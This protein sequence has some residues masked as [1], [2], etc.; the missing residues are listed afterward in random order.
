VL[1]N[2]GLAKIV[3]ASMRAEE[4]CSPDFRRKRPMVERLAIQIEAIFAIEPTD[5]GPRFTR[6]FFNTIGA[7]RPLSRTQV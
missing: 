3:T 7:K 5:L 4:K 1:K 2:F 6:E